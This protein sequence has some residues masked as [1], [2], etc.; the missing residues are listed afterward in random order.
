MI[1]LYTQEEFNKARG[2][3]YLLIECYG[4]GKPFNKEKKEI[5]FAL[6]NNNRCKYCSLKCKGNHTQKNVELRCTNCGSTFLRKLRLHKQAKNNQFCSSSCGATYNNKHKSHGT[7]R[8]KLEIWLEEQL[9]SIYPDL[10]IHYNQKDAINSEL[11]IYIPSLRLAFE[12][13]GIFHYEPIFGKDKLSQIQN[14]DQ[15]K[16][17]ACIENGVE[18]VLIDSSDLK[19]FKSEKAKKYLNI[20]TEIINKK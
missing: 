18:L 4:C 3:D 20:I 19:Y 17:Q 8:S 14:N 9:N 12:L 2:I 1:P 7:R 5:K 15:R 6:K 10:E 16:F 13:N 11:D